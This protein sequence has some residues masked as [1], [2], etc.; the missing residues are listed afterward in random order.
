MAVAYPLC[1]S[2]RNINRICEDPLLGLGFP[3]SVL[4]S[5]FFLRMVGVKDVV[6]ALSLNFLAFV[7]DRVTY[8]TLFAQLH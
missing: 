1:P 8:A 7:S 2:L 6:L 5:S 4:L 3:L